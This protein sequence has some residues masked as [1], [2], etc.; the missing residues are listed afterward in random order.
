MGEPAVGSAIERFMAQARETM[1]RGDGPAM[2]EEIGRHLSALAR[3][4]VI[5]VDLARSRLHGSDA[6]FTILARDPDGP[7]LMLSRFPEHEATRVHDHK[8]WGVACVVNGRD[9]HLHWRRLDDGSAPGRARVAV[10]DE[11]ELGEGEY[12]HWGDPPDDI[13]SQQGVGGAV[14]ELVFFGRDPMVVMRNYF[15]PDRGTVR[16][17]MPA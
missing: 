9:R 11:R 14:Y 15:D 16:E 8:S 2:R 17:E 1:A 10:D 7:I 5:S 6:R 12:V 13:H 3:S 4:G